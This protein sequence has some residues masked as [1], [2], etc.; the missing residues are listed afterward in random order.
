ML[1]AFLDL[2]AKSDED[3]A[4]MSVAVVVYKR[5]PYKNFVKPWE[6]MLKPWGVE[7]FHSTDFYCGAQGFERDTPERKKLFENDCMRIPAMVGK[8]A[9]RILIVSFRPREFESEAPAMWKEKFGTSIHS[10]AVQLAL[11]ANGWWA[12]VKAQQDDLFAYVME[13]GDTDEGE[14]LQIVERMRTEHEPTAKMIRVSSFTSALKGTARGLEA[15]DFVS[16]H[17][18]KYYMDKVRKGDADN[19]RKD[20]AA[21]LMAYGRLEYIFAT[22]DKLKFLFSRQPH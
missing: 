3:D 8:H 21:F 12:S 14:I 1:R 19:P 9:H 11:I 17:W 4:V 10:Q 2:G 7:A 6:K 16:W 20:F 22:G 5:T 15:A 13:S 18:N